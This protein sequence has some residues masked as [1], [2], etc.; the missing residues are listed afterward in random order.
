MYVVYVDSILARNEF[1]KYLFLLINLNSALGVKCRFMVG[2]IDQR[3]LR[4]PTVQAILLVPRN[5][6]VI[7][8]KVIE[9]EFPAWTSLKTFKH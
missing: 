4:P 7:P 2:T 6:R 5:R 8:L 9:K 1:Y 3:Y